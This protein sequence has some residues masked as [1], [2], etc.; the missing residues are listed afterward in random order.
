M[1]RRYSSRGLLTV[2]L[3]QAITTIGSRNCDIIVQ[4]KNVAP[5]HASLEYN[6]VTR[7]YW[8]KDH[9]LTAHTTVNGNTVYGQIELNTGDL[10][11]FGDSQPLVFENST[12]VPVKHQVTADYHDM[13]LEKQA[14]IDKVHFPALPRR[15]TPQSGGR[16]EALSSGREPPMRHDCLGGG[17]ARKSRDTRVITGRHRQKEKRAGSADKVL[18]GNTSSRASSRS[19]RADTPPDSDSPQV[20]VYSTGPELRL[21]GNPTRI[22]S[23]GNHLLQRVIRLQSELARKDQE[24]RELR[25]GSTP[26]GIEQ[27]SGY[28]SLLEQS[29]REKE[30][31]R[32]L[33]L[34]SSSSIPQPLSSPNPRYR[35]KIRSALSIDPDQFEDAMYASHPDQLQTLARTKMA[36]VEVYRAF[37]RTLAYELQSFNDR[38]LR[39]PVRDYSDVFQAIVRALEEPFSY[40][41]M[42]IEAD[43]EAYLTELGAAKEVTERLQHIV[44]DEKH[45]KI[46]VSQ[47]QAKL[48]YL[49]HRTITKK[50]IS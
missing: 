27:L 9:S 16:G 21:T 3:P 39:Q 31:L 2:R 42:E 5:I 15:Q 48:F 14:S 34:Q 10:V 43:C 49:R 17:A 44:R 30:R 50:K 7:S 8:L 23:V 24:I 13:F 4:A 47:A 46:S 25:A 1:L 37:V 32:D 36:E 33:L 40:K 19:P 18:Q 6:S 28:R 20:N 22:R 45:H 41:L 35:P 11:C 12:L 29:E 26:M 38:V